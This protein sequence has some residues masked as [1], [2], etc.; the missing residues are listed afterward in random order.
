MAFQGGDGF[1]IVSHHIRKSKEPGSKTPGNKPSV[2]EELGEV[3]PIARR[4]I[5]FVIEA[6]RPGNVR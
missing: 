1:V 6:D 4:S 5:E 2:L 3:T